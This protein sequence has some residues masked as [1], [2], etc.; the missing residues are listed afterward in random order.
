[1]ALQEGVAADGRADEPVQV[2]VVLQSASPGQT[3][4]LTSVTVGDRP[5]IEGSFELPAHGWDQTYEGAQ[6]SKDGASVGAAVDTGMRL[7]DALFSGPL[8]R[9]WA[10]VV[11]ESRGQEMRLVICSA[12]LAI[13]GLPWELLFDRVL[14]DRHLALVEGWSVVR[15]VPDPPPLP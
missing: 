7:F 14:V 3:N 5:P 10:Q 1:M 2:T 11:E 12:A 8:R 6:T 13:H 15:A 4:Y 9:C